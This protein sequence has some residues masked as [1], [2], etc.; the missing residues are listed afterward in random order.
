[1]QRYV[2]HDAVDRPR[3]LTIDPEEEI[4]TVLT[5]TSGQDPFL[6]QAVATETLVAGDADGRPDR[7]DL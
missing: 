7:P 3:D 2:L 4:M 1:V 6:L 5:R